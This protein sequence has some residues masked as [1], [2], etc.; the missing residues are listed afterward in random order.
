MSSA[1]TDARF[2]AVAELLVDDKPTDS[3]SD[4]GDDLHD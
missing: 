1:Y 4:V 2:S 3:M